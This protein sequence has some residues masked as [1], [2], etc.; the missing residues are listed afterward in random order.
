MLLLL[1]GSK[2]SRAPSLSS[3]G[4]ELSGSAVRTGDGP[5]FCCGSGSSSNTNL[6]SNSPSSQPAPGAA[7]IA[8]RQQGQDTDRV[9]QSY[10]PASYT[11]TL[12]CASKVSQ[13]YPQNFYPSPMCA[14]SLKYPTDPGSLRC[15][16]SDLS[17]LFPH[18][19]EC[20]LL[21]YLQLFFQV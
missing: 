12:K 16:F 18:D 4:T 15:N 3:A 5:W 2:C 9:I 1:E 17:A 8:P 11:A 10:L 14:S 20:F 13:R 7:P 19:G 6:N 21:G